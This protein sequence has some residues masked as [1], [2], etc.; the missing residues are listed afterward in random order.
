[1]AQDGHNWV[2]IAG[3][4]P[5]R[6]DNAARNRWKRITDPASATSGMRATAYKCSTCGELKKDHC[7]C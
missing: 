5:G 6:S 4:L 1:M 7:I 2:H 3:M